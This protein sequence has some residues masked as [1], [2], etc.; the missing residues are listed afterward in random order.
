MYLN[1]YVPILRPLVAAHLAEPHYSSHQMTYD[2]RRLS[3]KGFIQRL[4]GTHHYVLT[5]HGRRTAFF[6]AKS[7]ARILQ[8]GLSYLD[9]S[10][11]L[12]D[13]RLAQAWRRFDH[14]L[15]SFIQQPRLSP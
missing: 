13:S 1:A 10:P 15:T 9:P 4:P 3:R 5:L 12:P 14:A 2:L 8:P 11:P 6:F 7:Y